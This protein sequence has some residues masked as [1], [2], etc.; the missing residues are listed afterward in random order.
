[1]VST[2]P[3]VIF[4]APDATPEERAEALPGA[5]WPDVPEGSMYTDEQALR[6]LLSLPWE[7]QL[8]RWRIIHKQYN[9]GFECWMHNH[10]GVIAGMHE[11]AATLRMQL[12]DY[13]EQLHALKAEQVTQLSPTVGNPVENAEV[14]A[15]LITGSRVLAATIAAGSITPARVSLS[16]IKDALAEAGLTE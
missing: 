13:R 6:K 3:P 2:A 16:A 1:M 8:Y 5:D 12:D 14:T 4:L 10:R 15:E 9:E 7:L 11:Q